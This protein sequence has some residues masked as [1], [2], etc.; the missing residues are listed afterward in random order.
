MKKILQA[1]TGAFFVLCSN[2]GFSESGCIIKNEQDA[3]CK[4][5]RRLFSSLDP[6]LNVCAAEGSDLVELAGV[7][8]RSPY[9]CYRDAQSAYADGD[10]T[11]T[12][13]NCYFGAEPVPSNKPAANQPTELDHLGC[14]VKD[15]R[16]DSC[17]SGRRL[18][19]S[20]DNRLTAC[21]NQEG[22]SVKIL[23]AYCFSRYECFKDQNSVYQDGDTRYA[24]YNCYPGAA[25]I[26][27][28]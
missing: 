19:S 22:N 13:Y 6:Q 14:V 1:I 9:Q 24:W 4:S 12:W 7:Y 23:G 21:A 17:P 28:N 26:F 15:S 20:L 2:V 25:P 8:C 16:D 18:Y 10:K 11:F 27:K 3:S 5:G